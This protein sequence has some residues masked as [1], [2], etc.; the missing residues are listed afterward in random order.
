MDADACRDLVHRYYDELWNDWQLHLI[1]EILSP[2]LHFRS[3]LGT[4]VDGRE[5]FQGYLLG[6]RR[7]MPDFHH[8]IEW[9]VAEDG[10]AAARIIYSGTHEGELFGM[11]GTG[12][13]LSYQG[14]AFFRMADGA[15]REIWALGDMTAVRRQVMGTPT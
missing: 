7:A 1:E 2:D 3:S 10:A 12:H 13:R 9:L 14:A 8:E 11:T 15:I 5:D 4:M 6:L